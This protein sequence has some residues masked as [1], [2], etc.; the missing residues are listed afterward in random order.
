MKWISLLLVCVSISIGLMAFSSRFLKAVDP[1]MPEKI[2]TRSTRRFAVFSCS[3]HSAVLV[4][5]FYAPIIAASWQRLGYEPIVLFVGDFTQRNV[6]VQRLNST[7]TL[8]KRLG[9]QIVDVHCSESSSVKVSQM[10]RVFSGFLPDSLVHENDSILTTDSDLMPLQA[11]HYERPRNADGFIYNAR[12][13]GSFHRR[14]RT[15][16]MF[17]SSLTVSS[18]R[19]TFFLRF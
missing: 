6:S 12:C 9:A 19:S 1:S 13:C 3:I 2:S 7:R 11:K 16:R 17:P 4:Y 5:T 8:L 15:Y 10:L 18:P 14:G